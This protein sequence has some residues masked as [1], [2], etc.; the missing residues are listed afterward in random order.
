[1]TQTTSAFRLPKALTR[2][3][4]SALRCVPKN[5]RDQALIETLAGCGLRVSE[6]CDLRLDQVHWSGEAPSLRFV[7]KGNK[8]RIVPLNLEV[9]DALRTWLEVRGP[10]PSEYVFCQLRTGGRLSRKTVWDALQRYARRAGLRPVHPHMLRH[11]FGTALADRQVPIERIRELMGHASITTSQVYIA[12]STGQKREAVERLD[13]RPG[14]IRWLSRQRNRTFRFFGGQPRRFLSAGALPTVGRQAELA[15]LQ[16]HLRKGIDTLL[17]GP[18]GVGKSHLLSLLEREKL[19][20]LSGLT[21]QRQALMVLAEELFDRG[22]LRPTNGAPS[23][24]GEG[25]TLPPAEE[26]E[27]EPEGEP[28]LAMSAGE[29]P[30]EDAGDFES[31][32]KQHTRTSVQGW[33]KMILDSVQKDEW[34]LIVDDLSDLS[35]S[36]GK[37]LDLLAGKFVILA[38]SQGLKKGHEKHFWKFE[39]IELKNLPPD[40]ARTLIRQ[41]AQGAQVEDMALFETHLLQRSAGNPRALLESVARLRKESTVTREAVRELAHAGGRHQV[42]LT[43]ALLLLVCLLLAARFVARGM[44]ETEFYLLAGVGS[45]LAVGVRFFLYRMRSR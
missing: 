37:L 24:P 39:R 7:G 42:D 23:L 17:I 22:V 40:E 15:Q 38:G 1:M 27:P 45:A 25:E 21:P 26:P 12:V 14:L 28:A 20:R 11:A 19:I 8:E 43:P 16:D 35:T 5:P 31:F 33:A 41:A 34:T 29:A 36:T 6:A 32:K 30:Q 2:D 9:Q 18:V 10:A 13:E 44:G 4:L 3:E